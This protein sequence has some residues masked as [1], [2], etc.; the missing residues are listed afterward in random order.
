[1]KKIIVI[2]L[3][4]VSLLSAA[5]NKAQVKIN[6]G[7][8]I[9]SQ[10]VW[11]PVGYDH[12]DYYYLP[13]IESYYS[14]SKHQYVYQNGGNWVFSPNL[15]KQYSN[16]DVR[17]GYKV[18]LNEPQP[19]LHFNNDREKYSKYKGNRN[20]QEEI[21]E[22]NDPRYFIIKGHP[23]YNGNNQNGDK[24][25]GERGNEKNGRGRGNN[26]NHQ[27]GNYDN[28][29]DHNDNNHNGKGNGNDEN[30]KKRK[31]NDGKGKNDKRDDNN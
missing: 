22:S 31:V 23:H 30:G 12:V 1:M 28:D 14:V 18:V 19:Y 21:E 3:V 11:G 16:Y 13:D 9:G 27:D 4:A 5:S 20:H 2:V 29:N 26:R 17:K 25:D 24:H 8:N 10:P 7:A 6:L 15:P